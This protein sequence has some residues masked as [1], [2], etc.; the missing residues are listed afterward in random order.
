MSETSNDNAFVERRASWLELFFDLAYVAAIAQLTYFL[1]AA[2]GTWLEYLEFGILFIMIYLS[3]LFT[4]TYKNLTGGEREDRIERVAT[5]AQ[6]FFVLLMSVFVQTAFEV[7]AVGFIIGYVGT[8]VVVST[9]LARYYKMRPEVAPRNPFL[10]WGFRLSHLL[11]FLTIFIPQPFQMLWWV[12][13]IAFELA[14][15]HAKAKKVQNEVR[16]INRFHLPERLGLLT[17]LVMGESVIV[18]AVVNNIAAEVFTLTSGLIASASF[19]IIAGLW[20]MYFDHVDAFAIGKR[21]RLFPYI[22]VHIPILLGIMLIAVGTKIGML[23]KG[24]GIDPFWVATAGVALTILGFNGMKVA[25]GQHVIKFFRPSGIFILAL[26]IGVFV[27]SLSFVYA[28][29][30]LAFVFFTY[31]YIEHKTCHAELH[32]IRKLEA[33]S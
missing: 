20:W 3:W 18:V 2:D 30:A 16:I 5:I 32:A 8:R 1:I 4:A 26:V 14:L 9:L 22:Y 11:W 31:M 29:W 24:Y 23:D 17:I 10:L 13:L 25:T 6:M 28:M 27:N 33:V 19:A 12:I 15:P 7:G 21:F